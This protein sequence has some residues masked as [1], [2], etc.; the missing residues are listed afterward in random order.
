M[1][2]DSLCADPPGRTRPADGISAVIPEGRSDPQRGT[3]PDG[4]HARCH[5][6][7]HALHDLRRK[8]GAV[9]QA[10]LPVDGIVC[11]Y[12]PALG[13]AVFQLSILLPDKRFRY[14]VSRN[15]KAAL[16]R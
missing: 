1:E 16:I 4:L 8:P 6:L 13:G 9:S 5:Q 7:H 15:D 14:T 2:S 10:D 12:D 3:D 11:R